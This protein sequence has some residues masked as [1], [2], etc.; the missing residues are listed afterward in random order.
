MFRKPGAGKAQGFG[1]GD[2]VEGFGVELCRGAGTTV[3]G[4]ESRRGSRRSTWLATSVVTANP[5]IR[6]NIEQYLPGYAGLTPL[7]DQVEPRGVGGKELRQDRE[8]VTTT[9][10][11]YATNDADG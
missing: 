9:C 5:S 4:Y 6:Q 3:A 8:W 10:V 7:L 1:A 2:D 11:R